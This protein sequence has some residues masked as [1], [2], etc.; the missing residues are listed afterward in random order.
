M[1]STAGERVFRI[2]RRN[3]NLTSSG[4]ASITVDH[5]GCDSIPIT[6]TTSASVVT[7]T[8]TEAISPNSSKSQPT[9][10][11]AHS[12]NGGTS[13]AL[14]M[15]SVTEYTHSSD[16]TCGLAEP[17][18]CLNGMPTNYTAGSN[19]IPIC[20]MLQLYRGNFTA[21]LTENFNVS[22]GSVTIDIP[23]VAPSDDWALK[24]LVDKA[25]PVVWYYSTNVTISVPSASSTA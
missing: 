23:W 9:A 17:A 19:D 18:F 25:G 16:T 8:V 20:S 22:A 15:S 14:S 5:N 11:A 12:S 7:V 21:T 6:T 24:L 1:T 4:T 10:T 13:S 2:H 3:A